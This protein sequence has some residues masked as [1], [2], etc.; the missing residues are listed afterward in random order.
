MLPAYWQTW[1]FAALVFVALAVLAVAV[2]RWRVALLGRQAQRL[3]Q[4]VLQ[5]T[6]ELSH[7]NERLSTANADLESA[8]GE[9]SAAHKRLLETRERMVMQEKMASL[10]TLIAGVAHEINTPLGV[11]ITASSHLKLETDRFRRRVDA[12]EIRRD[13]LDFYLGMASESASMVD[14]NLGRAAQLVR[15]FKQVSVDRSLDERRR[16]D[17]AKYLPE[18]LESLRPMWRKRGAQ[19]DLQVAPGLELNSY[20]GAIAQIV[21]NLVENALLHAFD[22]GAAG[23]MRL[24]VR[25]DGD[26]HVSMVFA[27]SGKGIA[28]HDIARIF[29]PFFT[30]RRARGGTGLGLHI[31]FNL[32]NAKLGGQIDVESIV[33]SGTRFRIRIPRSVPV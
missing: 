31:V 15:S 19:F 23:S 32:V 3:Q 25:A 10:G 24:E 30:T 20:P 13:E 5:R 12:G 2:H 14:A 27:D 21:A 29:E 4:L 1:W 6:T 18:V 11:A 17:L 7:A 22:D 26:E 28:E 9:L 33:G 16:F 8:N